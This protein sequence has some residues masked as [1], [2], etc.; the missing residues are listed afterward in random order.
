MVRVWTYSNKTFLEK[1]SKD[2]SQRP[3]LVFTVEGRGYINFYE[4]LKY[5]E[6]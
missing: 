4:S 6:I 3:N 1:I 2:Y 5:E